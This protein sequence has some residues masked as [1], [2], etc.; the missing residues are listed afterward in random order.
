MADSP[1]VSATFLAY[2]VVVLVIGVIAWRR[3]ANLS[4]YILGGRRLGSWV[5]AFSAQASDMSG[6][7]LLGLPGYAYLAGLESLWLLMGLLIGTY[8]NWLLVAARL[9]RATQR[10]GD[11]LTLPDYFERRFADRSGL[12][13]IISASFILVFFTFYTSSG[14]VAG[15]KLFEAVFGMPYLWAV[16]A[17]AGAI[18]IYTFIGGFLAVSWT[19]F[20]QGSLMFLAL[21][22]VVVM[23]WQAVGGWAGT[24]AALEAGNPAL[25]DPFTA[26]SGETLS[27][28]AVLSLLGWGLGY[29]GQPHILARFMAARSAEHTIPVARRIAMSWVSV[30]LVCGTLVG[31]LGIAYLP[32]PLVGADS[33]KVFIYMASALFHPVV[34]GICLAGILAA[35]MSTADSQLLVA[36]SAVSEDFYKGLVRKQAEEGELLWV[37]RLAVIGIAVVAFGFA[38]DPQS[39]VLDLVAYAWAG[40]GAAFGPAIVLS[41]YWSG[42]TRN[43]AL[44]GIVV[45]GLTVILWRQLS[46]GIFDLYEIVPGVVF[47]SLAIL[48]GSFTGQ[49]RAS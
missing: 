26:A 13:R 24:A 12:L 43:G 1:V 15:G 23:A 25:L 22:F 20:L 28:I 29:V 44:A 34:A 9:R 19:D 45:G 41:L 39:K 2:L 6:W 49:T 36:S 40:F 17:G 47:S 48:L 42:M 5:T 18:V 10:Y 27:L 4:D 46:G 16:A 38:I 8:A 35:V 11:S 37:G 7:L 14:L 3:T 31:L 30:T 33:E 32:E 21:V